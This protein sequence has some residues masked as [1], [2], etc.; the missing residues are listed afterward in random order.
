MLAG[1]SPFAGDNVEDTVNVCALVVEGHFEFPEGGEPSNFDGM[2]RDFVRR[3]L[4]KDPLRRLGCG[5]G[6]VGDAWAHPW[7]AG[8]NPD[9]V[10]RRILQAPWVPPLQG[11]MDLSH[12]E[13]FDEEETE[14]T[15]MTY[16]GP[17]GPDLAWAAF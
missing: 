3:L 7:L 11:A 13:V 12:F 16:D 1:Y 6:G 4:V 14:H 17:D 9:L 2:S 5:R 15:T 10:Q 8:Y